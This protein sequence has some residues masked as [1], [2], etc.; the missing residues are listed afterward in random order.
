VPQEIDR[1]SRT[2]AH[3]VAAMSPSRG[4]FDE[5]ACE[6][7]PMGEVRL[8]TI[9]V[10]SNAIRLRIAKLDG[11]G[12]VRHVT[13]ARASVRLG[14]DVFSSGR[15]S[16]STLEQAT[17]ALAS[18][19]ATMDDERVTSYRAVATSATREASNRADFVRRAEREA[20]IDLE[21]IDGHEEARL[22]NVAV[23]GAVRLVGR[24]ALADVGGGSTEITLLDGRRRKR[25][26]SLPLGTV[27]LL[28]A[29]NPEG[30]AVGRRK[31]GILTEVV[32]RALADVASDLGRAER[33][34]A[35]GGTVTALAKLCGRDGH[36]VSVPRL[37]HLLE[38]LRR[39][40]EDERVTTFG[41]RRD[42]ADTI[43]PAAVILTRV[44]AA[45]GATMIEAPGVGIRD[46][47]LAEL[48]TE[49]GSSHSASVPR[50]GSASS[51]V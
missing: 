37:A 38:R 3:D 14:S 25:S 34:V 46:G 2:R 4:T 29:W 7:C 43:L 12:V 16:K 18:F 41:I 8:G 44:A 9:D 26:A 21:T 1:N 32:D 5:R 22:V 48:A 23:A 15:L 45:T 31:L 35:T 27:R 6:R 42:R 30:G 51:L 20:G 33:L 11:N 39:M 17:R 13:S 24:V 36:D 49:R 40:T 10:G 47:I 50:L 28:E 19:R